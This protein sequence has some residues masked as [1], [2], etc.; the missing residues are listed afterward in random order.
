MKVFFIFVISIIII[1]V[2]S[3]RSYYHGYSN[4]S[5]WS[6]SRIS[7]IVIPIVVSLIF[8]VFIFVICKAKCSK[9]KRMGVLPLSTQIALAQQENQYA[10]PPYVQLP[11]YEQPPPYSPPNAP[12]EPTKVMFTS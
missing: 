6:S 5:S 2:C 11:P 12:F 10:P 7:S 8:I 9:K 1:N 3:A 4:S